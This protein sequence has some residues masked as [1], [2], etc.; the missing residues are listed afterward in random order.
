MDS[1]VIKG[2]IYNRETEEL[3][4]EFPSGKV[5][6][7]LN[8]EN[9]VANQLRQSTSPGNYYNSH[10]KG[11][12]K[13]KEPEA[14]EPVKKYDVYQ[15]DEYVRKWVTVEASNE[16]EALRKAQDGEGTTYTYPYAAK[17]KAWRVSE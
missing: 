10:I 16:A 14:V 8:V 11:K 6:T 2:V 1:S 15:I 3:Q 9:Y 5:Y 4:L 17:R 12:Y 13:T 7:Y